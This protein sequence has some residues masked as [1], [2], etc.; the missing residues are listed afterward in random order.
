M[1]TA[2]HAF[3][4][5]IGWSR[6]ECSEILTWS[7]VLTDRSL[8]QT[9]IVW[10]GTFSQIHAWTAKKEPI[11]S[12]SSQVYK[13][14]GFES[15]NIATLVCYWK[16]KGQYYIKCKCQDMKIMEWILHEQL[17]EK[18]SIDLQRVPVTINSTMP[19]HQNASWN[20]S[21]ALFPL[22]TV[23][24]QVGWHLDWLHFGFG[25]KNYSFYQRFG[26][27]LIPHSSL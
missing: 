4:K 10:H 12:S 7:T 21:Y 15:A 11:Q 5:N 1:C 14:P 17:L 24:W 13:E 3:L 9:H 19:N 23:R 6:R 2:T 8:R 22:C 26:F 20:M 16:R 18:E 27:A 25:W